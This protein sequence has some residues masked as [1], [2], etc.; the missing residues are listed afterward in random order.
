M[1][2]FEIKEKSDHEYDQY[3]KNLDSVYDLCRPCKTRL[4]NHLR[5]IDSQ[6]G[7]SL[8]K[9][10]STTQ[11]SSI[12]TGNGLKGDSNHKITSKA[13]VNSETKS[14]LNGSSALADTNKPS[15]YVLNDLCDNFKS[16]FKKAYTIAGASVPNKM[17]ASDVNGS[18]WVN[19]DASPTNSSRSPSRSPIRKQQQPRKEKQEDE[20]D[21]AKESTSSS[22]TCSSLL[23]VFE[24][25]FIYVLLALVFACDLVN[26]LN[27]SGVLMNNTNTNNE[28][29]QTLLGIYRQ[30][31]IVLLVIVACALHLAYKRPKINRLFMS[32]GFLFD[33]V[34]HVNFF[35]FTHEEQFILESFVSLFLVGYLSIARVYNLFQ[36]VRYV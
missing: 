10:R 26:L 7:E 30:T 22:I 11:T 8:L 18:K 23:I 15:Y 21:L 4:N 16:T 32:V 25:F 9:Q 14:N 36:L 28:W 3:K 6:I 24:D 29:F 20:Q 31:P 35:E 5:L 17:R 19:G 2:C 12:R 33:L 13:L 34:V 27:D 1:S